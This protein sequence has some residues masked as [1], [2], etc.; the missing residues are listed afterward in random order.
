MAKV[1]PGQAV[2]WVRLGPR[3][4]W[5]GRV[6]EGGIGWDGRWLREVGDGDGDEDEDGD[7]YGCVRDQMSGRI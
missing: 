2:G 6:G 5:E 3:R 7:A 1:R 4:L